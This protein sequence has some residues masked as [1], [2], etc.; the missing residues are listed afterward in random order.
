MPFHCNQQSH[1]RSLETSDDHLKLAA[2]VPSKVSLYPRSCAVDARVVLLRL[3]IP[4]SWPQH[5][6]H[7]LASARTHTLKVW[8]QFFTGS[9]LSAVSTLIYFRKKRKRVGMKIE[10]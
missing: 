5:V 9:C 1:P 10:I 4:L 2:E 7:V 8:L 6:L 3:S